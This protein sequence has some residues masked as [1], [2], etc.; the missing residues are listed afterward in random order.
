[1]KYPKQLCFHN[2]PDLGKNEWC[3]FQ[4]GLQYDESDIFML[5]S[6]VS[7][8]DFVS[9]I[10]NHM[11]NMTPI[12]YSFFTFHSCQI[13]TISDLLSSKFILCYHLTVLVAPNFFFNFGT[14]IGAQIFQLS[15]VPT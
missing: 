7:C 6:A 9:D 13:S 14:F 3:L 5:E 12:F 11:I 4:I 1:M 8:R 10:S 15:V 2:S